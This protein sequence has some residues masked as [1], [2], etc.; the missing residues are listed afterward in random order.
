MLVCLFAMSAI[1]LMGAP[2]ESGFVLVD[3]GVA[4]A[5]IVLDNRPLPADLRAAEI[6]QKTVLKM[7]GALLQIRRKTQKLEKAGF[8][9]QSGANL[10]GPEDSFS[11]KVSNEGVKVTG[12]RKGSIY[13]VVDLLEKNFG[14]RYYSPQ[15][16]VFPKKN[17]L[18]L[19]VGEAT[20][21]PINTFRAINGDFVA[22][23]DWIDWLRLTTT[24]EMFGK[25]YYVHT[26]HKLVPPETFFDVQPELFALVHG[27]RVR[28]QLCP[29]NPKNVEIA[30]ET[31]RREM[32]AQPDKKVWSVSQ[33]DNETFCQCPDCMKVMAEE[34]SPSGP[35][36][37]FVNAV[38]KHFPDKTISTLAYL[39]SRSAPKVTKPDPNVQIMLCTIELSR[40]LPISKDPTS[41]KFRDDIVNWGRICH[42][43]YLWDYTVNFSHQVA[44]FPNLSV[45]APNLQFFVENNARQQ[46]QQ[47]NTSV[48][49]EFSELKSY[50]ISR[51]LWNPHAN[52]RAIEDDFLNG[53]YG[54][55]APFL[56]SYIDDL[57]LELAQSKTRLDIY[58][59]PTAH[60]TDYLSAKNVAQY[61]ELLDHAEAVVAGQPELLQRVKVARLPLD[62]AIIGIGSD[63]MFGPRGFFDTTGGKPSLRKKME[64]VLE[65][66]NQTCKLNHV[67]SV[68]ESNLKPSDFYA[69][70][71]QML[72]LQIE[73]N[74]AFQKSVTAAPMPSPKYGH[75]DLTLLTNGVRGANDF[76]SQWLGWE[77]E[78][79]DLILDLGGPI[80]ATEATVDSIFVPNSWILHPASVS[81]SV[82]TE[83][84]SYVDVGTVPCDPNE[85]NQPLVKAFKFHLP[86]TAIRYVKLHVQG[87]HEL[88]AWHSAVGSKSWFFLDEITVK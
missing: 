32:L 45:L 73:G 81:C 13:A 21:R 46:F 65:D 71:K 72:D 61:E 36:L 68:N 40:S 24:D 11:V 64:Q 16:Q 51:L 41:A 88:P 2:L 79:C 59:P 43:I 83:G 58:E 78:D 34:G 30:V 85:R 42:N 57:E 52:V 76:R 10:S 9:I 37:R 8:F 53:F 28:D 87:T 63:Q 66:F 62:Y 1:A 39:Y 4:K 22:D 5:S 38:A 75:G 67:R 25:G 23:P 84:V 56:R 20:D 54:P 3:H 12:I 55:A 26:F 18:A 7:S 50:L 60:Q 77:G 35:I 29:S 19:P 49:H 80:K 82:S 69:V 6:L 17:T 86:A 44:P 48:G 74:H 31:L 14:C 15:V 33:N 47:T 27:R 70:Q